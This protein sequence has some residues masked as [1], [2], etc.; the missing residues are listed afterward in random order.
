MIIGITGASGFIGTNLTARLKGLGH[1]VRPIS[2]RNEI[3]LVL[4]DGCDGVVHLSGE[5]IAQRWTDAARKRIVDSRVQ[6]TR[7]LIAEMGKL[8]KRPEVLISASAVGYYGSRGDEKLIETSPPGNDFLAKVTVEWERE[9]Q[10]AQ[11]LG[12]RVVNPRIGVVLG[13]NG[14]ALKRMLLPFR[15]GLGGRL[16]TGKQWMSWIH[17]DD[18]CSLLVFAIEREEVRGAL[19]AVAPQPVT[20]ARFTPALGAAL[21]RPTIF[22]RA[23]VRAEAYV[24]GDVAGAAGRP[25]RATGSSTAG[26]VSVSI[27]GN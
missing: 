13:K 24:R 3:D 25:A 20:N 6:G 19:N 10:E 4:L 2:L 23:C 16:G 12:I 21:H 5:P 14:G 8:P 7:Q 18:L 1:E 27:S 11:K 15:L 9:A 17:I 26:R 22:P